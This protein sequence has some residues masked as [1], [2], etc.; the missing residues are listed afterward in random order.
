MGVDGVL[1]QGGLQEG[2]LQIVS[3]LSNY[4]PL[5]N[6]GILLGMACIRS[7]TLGVAVLLVR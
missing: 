2:C 1:R 6:E 3:W 5:W 7:L 4:V